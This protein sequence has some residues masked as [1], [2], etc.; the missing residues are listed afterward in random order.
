MGYETKCHVRVDDG[1]G[2]IRT[3][4]AATVLLETDDLV[5]RGDAR[6]RIPRTSIE[7]VATRNG[8]VTITSAAGVV[9][10][11]LGADAAAKWRAKLEEPPKALIDKLDVKPDAKVWLLGITDP[12]L[13]AQIKSRTSNVSNGRSASQCDLVFVQIETDTQLDRID[14]AAAAMTDGGAIWAVHPKGKSGVADTTIFGRA[15]KL[16][17]TYTKV[18]RVSETLTAEKLVKPLAARKSAR[19]AARR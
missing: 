9:A 7:G 6:I 3:A 5:V 10:L 12:D 18:A 2:Q 15:T 1:T 11:T 19:R 8:V 17:L 16:G 13:A 4:D 14:K